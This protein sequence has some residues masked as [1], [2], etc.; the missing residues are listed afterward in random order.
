[1]Q[2]EDRYL[3]YKE[4][5][6]DIYYK[7]KDYNKCVD[8]IY[9]F[10]EVL[11]LD[12]EDRKHD[13]YYCYLMLSQVHKQL[14]TQNGITSLRFARQ[15][16]NYL[17]M[18]HSKYVEYYIKAA[19]MVARGYEGID[20]NKAVDYYNR[21]ISLC[22]SHNMKDRYARLLNNVAWLTNNEEL[23]LEVLELYKELYREG[24]FNEE[25]LDEIYDTLVTIYIHNNKYLLAQKYINKIHSKEM[26]H[27]LT[28]KMFEQSNKIVNI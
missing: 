27:L 6:N 25:T 15:S 26:C 22:A 8:E 1:M 4:Q 17:E 3:S 28:A 9:K 11:K 13:F 7:I 19:W 10:I 14:N 24:K 18:S 23:G 21:C 16:L 2:D 20:K 12:T 5:I